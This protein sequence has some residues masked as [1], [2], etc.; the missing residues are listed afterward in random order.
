MDYDDQ[1]SR[2][3]R[4][5]VGALTAF[6]DQI[7]AGALDLKRRRIRTEAALDQLQASMRDLVRRVRKSKKP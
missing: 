7:E 3:D 2:E 5:A 1:L 4:R 6:F